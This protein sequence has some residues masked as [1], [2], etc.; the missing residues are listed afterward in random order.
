MKPT[1]GPQ[2]IEA[3][4]VARDRALVQWITTMFWQSEEVE[5]LERLYVVAFQAGQRYE[6]G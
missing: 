1:P 4:L 3:L 2:Q 6:E 5:K